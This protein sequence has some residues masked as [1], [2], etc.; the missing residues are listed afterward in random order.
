MTPNG[1]EFIRLQNALNLPKGCTCADIANALGGVTVFSKGKTDIVSNGQITKEFNFASSKRRVGG[2]GDITAGALGLFSAWAPNN[3]FEAAA[4]ASE[5]VRKAAVLAFS[6]K[7]RSTITSDIIDE[8]C[9]AL[10]ESWRKTEEDD[11]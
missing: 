6:K 2:Q 11:D 7:A 3:Y 4:A 10:P 8:I 1:G 5:A 9:N